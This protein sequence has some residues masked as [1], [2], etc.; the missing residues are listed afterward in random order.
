[1]VGGI[2][3]YLTEFRLDGSVE[4][5]PRFQATPL[6]PTAEEPVDD[7]TE[8]I[9][10]AERKGREEGHA[11]AQREFELALA[12]ERARHEEQLATERANWAE[13]QGGQLAKQI[14]TGLHELEERI[15][16][17]AGRIML[18][19]LTEALR[20]QMMA[21]LAEVFTS[22]LQNRQNATIRVSGPK[23]MLAA[24]SNGL[25]DK[26]SSVE[27]VSNDAIDVSILVGET[28][29]ETQLEAWIRHLAQAVK[30]S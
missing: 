26:G 10:Q 21:G 8:R 9:R 1:M 11:S 14:E 30:P 25:G 7:T 19:F 13:Q 20:E 16:E 15:A 27:F 3:Q 12:A 6:K 28:L 2:A 23:D 24:L 5:E 22:L 17:S 4:V 29:V 18:P